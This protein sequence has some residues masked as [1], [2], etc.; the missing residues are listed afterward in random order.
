VSGMATF[1]R[2]R[3]GLAT[4]SWLACLAVGLAAAALLVRTYAVGPRNQPSA[5]LASGEVPRLRSGE[6][7]APRSE[8][9]TSGMTRQ[10]AVER[11]VSTMKRLHELAESDPATALGLAVSA[12]VQFPGSADAP[13][14]G[15]LIC[16]CLVN[17]G[18]FPEAVAAARVLREQYP[19]TPWA[20]DAERHLL[21]NPMSDPSERGHGHR[22]ELE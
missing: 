14:R 1:L 10:A 13:E 15:W 12:N 9:A 21:V 18:R 16:R 7:N 17:L 8:I 2:R 6:R 11:E 5:R 20:L 4:L 22:S 3:S 19:D